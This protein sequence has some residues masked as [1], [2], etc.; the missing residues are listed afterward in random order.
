[1]REATKMLKMLFDLF[2]NV[3]FA[4]KL[5]LYMSLFSLLSRSVDNLVSSPSGAVNVDV[6]LWAV[7]DDTDF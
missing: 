6:V 3:G 1:M 7:S 5:S 4:Q 2:K